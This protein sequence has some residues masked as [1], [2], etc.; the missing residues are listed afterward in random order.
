MEQ[1]PMTPRGYKML[2]EK[3]HQLKFVERPA[4]VKEIEFARSLGDLSENFEY[5]SAKD[6]QGMIEA[7]IKDAEAKIVLAQVID[8]A[9]MKDDGVVRFSA[10]VT[11]VDVK[12][13]EESTYQIVGE[14]EADI[15]KGLISFASPIAK[16]LIGKEE[17]DEVNIR[18]PNGAKTVEITEVKYITE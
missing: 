2:E 10:T 12:T 13:E 8:P 14:D 4:I 17:G 9:K 1:I 5:H 18:T 3:L 16:A 15:K 7:L 6:R 11:F